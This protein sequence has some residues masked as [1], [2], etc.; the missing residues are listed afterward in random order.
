MQ[1][2][3]RALLSILFVGIAFLFW[4]IYY[5]FHLLYQEQYLLFLYIPSYFFDKLS[6]PGGVGEYI[7]E[8]L[9]Q[10]YY[11]PYLGALIVALLLGGIQRLMYR[12]MLKM[13]RTL[14]IGNVLSFI[15]SLGAW[16]FLCDENSLLAGIV[17]LLLSMGISYGYMS[18]SRQWVKYVYVLGVFPLLYWCVGGVC[19]VTLCLIL[20]YEWL[21]DSISIKHKSAISLLMVI[22]WGISVGYAILHLQYPVSRLIT[23]IGY[24]RFPTLI[25][26][27]GVLTC[28]IVVL[29][30]G[31]VA[32]LPQY[33][34]YRSLYWSIQSIVVLTLGAGWIYSATSMK[35]ERDMAYDYWASTCQWQ[36]II[37][38]AEQNNPD[39]PLSVV[40]LNLA[41][42]KTGQLGERMFQFFQNGTDGLIPDFVR[43]YT[44]PLT[45]NEVY[46]H[47]GMIN[48]SQR[49]VFEAMEANPSYHKSTRCIRRLAETN[50][51]NGEYKV[52]AKYLNL[53]KHTL[54]YKKWAEET[55]TYLY[56][57]DKINSHPEW[58]RLRKMRYTEDFLFSEN[59][60]DMMLGLLLVHN[61]NNRLAFE[62]LLA[63]TLLNR[64]IASFLKYYPIGKNMG[65]AVIPRSYQEALVYVWT[66]SHPNFQGMPWSISPV[67]MKEVTEFATHYVRAPKDEA[68]F[69][70]RFGKSY[71][72]YLLFRK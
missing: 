32:F 8:F 49:Y 6:Y 23:G 24:Y 63:Y 59:E 37:Q 56:E 16:A 14:L 45:V 22:A 5:P 62:Y 27:S 11:Y 36:Q 31:G 33:Q 30:A 47:L 29:L 18:L 34:K 68:F 60:K 61:K 58:G 3:I 25:P 2:N 20:A 40:C 13:Q 65:Y 1:N 7:A 64:D 51:L 48:T 9:T 39:T 44:I 69:L 41:L 19:I 42:G 71:W 21:V 57:E 55:E 46:F 66:Q 26:F 15:P 28:V 53:L 43:D 17:S 35:K 12:I 70:N 54:F 72:Y 67:V 52:A 50:L 38:S 10:F 4:A